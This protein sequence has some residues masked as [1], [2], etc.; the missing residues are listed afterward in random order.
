MKIH[1]SFINIY[2]KRLLQNSIIN[3]NVRRSVNAIKTIIQHIK[4]IQYQ[5]ENES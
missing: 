4:K 3:M 5:K 1:I 2:L